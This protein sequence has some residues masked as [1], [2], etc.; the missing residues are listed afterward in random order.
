M[1]RFLKPNKGD[2]SNWLYHVVI[3]ELKAAVFH[4]EKM[5]NGETTAKVEFFTSLARRLY[6]NAFEA[7]AENTYKID[8]SLNREMTVML[9]ASKVGNKELQKPTFFSRK[10]IVVKSAASYHCVS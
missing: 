1:W 7:N 9:L 2:N 6:L 3:V 4:V 5:K 10:S 8:L